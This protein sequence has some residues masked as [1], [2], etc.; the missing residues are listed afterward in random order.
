MASWNMVSG[1]GDV[2]AQG[3]V[4]V[5]AGLIVF[6]LIIVPLLLFGVELIIVGCVLAGSLFG[7]VVLG[8]PWL[9]EARTVS[10]SPPVRV[11]EWK[12]VGWQR[13]HAHIQQVASE[14]AAGR[15]PGALQQSSL[16]A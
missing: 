16:V 5:I 7:R 15:D 6:A 11:L 2:D 10:G 8:R 3:A 4:L 14:L 13:S 12:I 1:F 9:V